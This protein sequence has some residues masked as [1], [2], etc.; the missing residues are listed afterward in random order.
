MKPFASGGHRT[1]L[2]LPLIGVAALAQGPSL[3][4]FG[5]Q[6]PPVVSVPDEPSCARCTVTA[7]TI[8]ELGDRDGPG[9]IDYLPFALRVDSRGRFWV[10][11]HDELPKVFDSTGRF[12]Q[13]IGSVG[14]GPGEFRMPSDAVAIG[15]S[16]LVVDGSLAR[17][18]VVGPALKPIR[19]IGVRWGFGSPLVL[20]W[21]RE[22]VVTASVPIPERAGLR[23]HRV[24]FGADPATIVSSFGPDDG[25]MRPGRDLSQRVSVST[26][27]RTFWTADITR[28]RLHEWSYDGRQLRSLLRT[29][30]WFPPDVRSSMGNR[31]TSPSP[32]VAALV[33]DSTGLIWV[34]VRVA[35]AT[36][37]EAWP[38]AVP[39][40]REYRI[41]EIAWEKLTTTLVE[42]IDPHAGR[43]LARQ[44]LDTYLVNALSSRR[45]VFYAV[46]QH[47]YP[48]LSVLSFELVGR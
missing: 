19:S 36:W 5:L 39:G 18:T 34:F 43:V 3:P 23:L 48:R 46:D 40:K 13:T 37:R 2:Y 24:S 15:D 22:V 32:S 1:L 14:S 20:A 6:G 16:M 21:P 17:V 35:K 7:R 38:P 41:R 30:N 47:G 11:N 29:Q 45:A 26:T 42:V 8:A 12:V 25:E 10:M 33:Q 44:P 31:T 27:G 28:Y 9:S 4:G